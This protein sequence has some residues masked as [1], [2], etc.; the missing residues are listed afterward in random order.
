MA[1]TATSSAVSEPLG[2]ARKI[3][4]SAAA[5]GPSFCAN[6]WIE[7]FRKVGGRVELCDDG[8]V[9]VMHPDPITKESADIMGQ[10]W[11]VSDGLEK[12][13]LATR[14]LR[15]ASSERAAH[16]ITWLGGDHV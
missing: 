7:Q 14:N 1:E 3:D 13:A 6:A 16:P 10:L 11:H 9:I 2:A 8:G 4:Q 12:V 15:A 5:L